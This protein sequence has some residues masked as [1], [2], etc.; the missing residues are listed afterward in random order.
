MSVLDR[1]GGFGRSFRVELP[2]GSFPIPAGIF[3]DGT[4]LVTTGF[5]FRPSRVEG[6]FRDTALYGRVSR[7]G[8]FLDSIGRFPSLEFY[9]SGTERRAAAVSLPFG[10]AAQAAVRGQTAYVGVTDRYEI[11]RYAVD[12]RLAGVIRTAHEPVAVSDEDVER[13]KEEQLEDAGDNFRRTMERMFANMPIPST[14]PAFGRLVVDA[15]AYLWVQEYARPGAERDRWLVYD[16]GG[17]LLGMVTS[18]SDLRVFE[19]GEDYLLG[20]WRDD[21]D[22]EHVQLY[23]LIKPGA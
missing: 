8:D 16:P 9:V 12:G 14:M 23:E 20:T 6:V 11:F 15:R 19:I 22:V 1:E 3:G 18:P 17:R 13:V 2:G 4:V 5:S 21:L 7:H 10:R